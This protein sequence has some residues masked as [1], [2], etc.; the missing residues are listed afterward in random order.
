MGLIQPSDWKASW[1]EPALEEDVTKTGPV[2]MLRREFTL[3][4]RITRARAPTRRA[5]GSTSC[6]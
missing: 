1:I 2:P 3:S 4:G 5:T 6:T